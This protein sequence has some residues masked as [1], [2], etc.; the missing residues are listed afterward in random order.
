MRPW[1]RMR[2]AAHGWARGHCALAL[3][4]FF[5]LALVSPALAER[6]DDRYERKRVAPG[7]LISRSVACVRGDLTGGGYFI[8]G[9]PE[10]RIVFNVTANFPLADGR[11][12]VDL[13]NV[14]DRAQPLTLLVYALCTE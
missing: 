1:S 10:D 6:V 8:P 4:A 9:Q 3:G 7:E 13:R 5:S 2:A 11:W 12:R 14:S